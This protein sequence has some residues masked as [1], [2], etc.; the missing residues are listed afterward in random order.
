MGGLNELISVKY[1]ALSPDNPL[2]KPV[3]GD[4][5]SRV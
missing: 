2:L 4:V 5:A 3:W 1:L